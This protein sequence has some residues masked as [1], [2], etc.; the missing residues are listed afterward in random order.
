MSQADNQSDL[1]IDKTRFISAIEYTAGETGFS[2]ALIEKDYFCSVVL[3]YFSKFPDIGLVFKGGTLLAKVHAGFYRLS[4]DLDFSLP[5]DVSSTR[6]QRSNLVK[7]SKAMIERITDRFPDICV[8]CE[9]KGSN[10]SKQYNAQLR[11]KSILKG[12][13]DKIL[14]DIGL[15]EC[16]NCKPNQEKINTI[17]QDPFLKKDLM[18]SFNFLSLDKS[19]AYAEKMRAAL[20][21]KKLAIR[22]FYDLHHARSLNLLDFSTKYFL[23]TLKLKLSLPNLMIHDFSKQQ[24][25]SLE[26]KIETELLPTL[27]NNF[28]SSFDL[29][30][31]ISWL[32]AY[33]EKHLHP[34]Q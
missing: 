19:E 17:I 8:E 23:E 3:D 5:I 6:K 12:G 26:K 31:T 24:I 16:L 15:R 27:S 2:P 13:T 33:K 18:P 20:T 21:R 9:L 10:E 32:V 28:Q 1:H 4:E 7:P 29:K 14:I 11:Y 30:E 25:D 22:D 34:V